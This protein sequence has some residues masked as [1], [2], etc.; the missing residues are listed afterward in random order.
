MSSNTKMSVNSMSHSII[1]ILKLRMQI[2]FK[3]FSLLMW[4]IGFFCAFCLTRKAF[5]ILLFQA[6]EIS[7]SLIFEYLQKWKKVTVLNAFK[8]ILNTYH[9]SLHFMLQLPNSFFLPRLHGSNSSS[10]FLKFTLSE[11]K[12][13]LSISIASCSSRNVKQERNL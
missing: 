7:I 5:S 11:R 13:N 12:Q 8:E 9:S 2:M 10:Y 4:K 3:R 6:P 1:S